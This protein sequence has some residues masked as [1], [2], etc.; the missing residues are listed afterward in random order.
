[1]YAITQSIL[2]EEIRPFGGCYE[3]ISETAKYITVKRLNK[4]GFEPVRVFKNKVIC[5]SEKDVTETLD[6]F[7]ELIR[8]S[9]DDHM[10]KVKHSIH[11]VKE[12]C[13]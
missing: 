9:F 12:A 3:V 1:M 7:N 2:R 8:Q 10:G 6:M 5:Y 13:K 4:D 11:L